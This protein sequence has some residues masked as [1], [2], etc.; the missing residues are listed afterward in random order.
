M[1][2]TSPKRTI[3]LVEDEESVSFVLGHALETDGF[4]VTIAKDGEEGLRLALEKHPD[5]ILADLMLPKMNGID[6]IKAI[7][8]DT[9]GK[10]A[11]II[12]LSNVSD[13][14]SINEAMNHEVFTYI[15]K[16]DL[17]MKDIIA[18]IHAHLAGA[19]PAPATAQQ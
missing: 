11:G 9:W 13:V 19:A 10:V 18:K 1:D 2:E 5:L 15:V 6:M 16:G 4:E 8:A 7:R 12:I 3:L 17:S 14:N